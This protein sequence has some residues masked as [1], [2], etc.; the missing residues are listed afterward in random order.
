MVNYR[1]LFLPT[2]AALTA[3][4]WSPALTPPLLADETLTLATALDRGRLQAR[5]TVA[6]SA[7]QRAA[8][9]RAKEAAGYRLPQVRLSEQWIRTDS[10]ADAFGMLLNQERFSFPAFVAG[11][12]NDPDPLST[13]ITRLEVEIPIWTG[14]ELRRASRR[15]ASPPRRRP[16]APAGPA[17]RRRSPPPRRGSAWPRRVKPRPC[18]RSRARPSPRTSSSPA[19]TPRQ[20]MLV[21]S[22]LLRAEVELARLDDLLAEAR[23]N[24]RIAESN[25]AFRLGEPLDTRYDLEAL[26]DPPPIAQEGAGWLASAESRSD[27]AA[28]RKLL[29]AGDLEAKALKGGIFPRIGLVARHD[30]VDDQLFGNNGD[31]TTIAALASFDLYDGGKRRA[32]MAA[33]R[34]TP[35]P[36]VPMSS[37]SRPASSSKR[38]RPSRSLRSPSSAAGPLRPRSP[39]RKRPC[40]SSRIASV[41]A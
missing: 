25:L 9:A 2:L 3:L 36:G 37:A 15:P 22:D 20:G 34:R 1:I 32:A 10:P 33:A 7:R 27:L 18:S 31:S 39:R 28:A 19:P 6:A 13:A 29:E 5:E 4:A 16:K 26:A 12:P 40:A 11:N 23:G 30:L 21:R 24:V 8:E 14:G 38:S 41:P 35:R 17:I